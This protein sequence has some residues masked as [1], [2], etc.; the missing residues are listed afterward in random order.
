M[1]RNNTNC[2][3]TMFCFVAMYVKTMVCGVAINSLEITLI[4]QPAYSDVKIGPA[5]ALEIGY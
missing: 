2:V 1:Y 5:G 4:S 3:K